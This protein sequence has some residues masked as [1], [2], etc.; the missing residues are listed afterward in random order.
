[1][2]VSDVELPEVLCATCGCLLPSQSRLAVVSTYEPSKPCLTVL[3]LNTAQV[4]T[5]LD[6]DVPA[7]LARY[8]PHASMICL[9]GG[10]GTVAVFDVRAGR[11]K[12]AGRCP[13]FP[14]K[15]QMVCSL[16]LAGNTICASALRSQLG[17]LGTQDLV[18][19]TSLRTL[20]IRSMR[21][22]GSGIYCAE[23]AASLRWFYGSAG[24]PQIL[25]GAPSGHLQLLDSSG[26]MGEPDETMLSLSQRGE[27]LLSLDVSATSQ[28][29]CAGGANGSL[30]IGALESIEVEQLQSNPYASQPELAEP[31]EVPYCPLDAPI[32]RMPLPPLQ[33]PEAG[34]T[35]ASAWP[36]QLMGK[37]G[38]RQ[39]DPETHLKASSLVP[40]SYMSLGSVSAAVY[41]NT[42]NRPPNMR[43]P[44]RERPR[45]AGYGAEGDYGL[46]EGEGEGERLVVPEAYAALKRVVVQ[47]GKF[48]L[49]EDFSFEAHNMSTALTTLDN[50]V[51]NC[52]CN[53]VL[54]IL[55]Q[56]PW[57]R[58]H[59]LSSLTRSQFVLSDELG[60]LFSMMDRSRGG[61]CQPR[62]F[63][64]ALHQSREATALK[65]VDAVDL[66]GNVKEGA[67]G[68]PAVI[69]KFTAFLLEHLNKEARE[70]ARQ[71]ARDAAA[72][73]EAA[74]LEAARK[75]GELLSGTVKP[76]GGAGEGGG[77][78][79]GK[80]EKLS[81]DAIVAKQYAER[82]AR[83]QQQQQ[84]KQEAS[85][86]TDG[87][88][89]AA[90]KDK[91]GGA[92][93]VFDELFGSVWQETFTF[94]GANAKDVVKESTSLVL[95]LTLP[96]DEPSQPAQQTPQAA[97]AAAGATTTQP[98]PPSAAAKA[99]TCSFE[100]ALAQCVCKESS[101]KT[102]CGELGK[103]RG[104][105]VTK[106]LRAAPPAMCLLTSQLGS[107]VMEEWEDAHGG[108]PWLPAAFR[109][110]LVDGEK[111]A[112]HAARAAGA[113]DAGAAE[114]AAAV[115][116]KGASASRCARSSASPQ[117]ARV[118]APAGSG[119]L[120]LYFRVPTARKARKAR[121]HAASAAAGALAAD[122]ADDEAAARAVVSA[123]VAA[124][125]AEVEAAAADAPDAEHEPCCEPSEMAGA[126]DGGAAQWY[127]WND[128][129][130]R[131]VGAEEV[132]TAHSDWKRPCIALYTVDGLAARLPPIP[133]AV[134]SPVATAASLS[135]NYSLSC[136]PPPT[137]EP[138]FTPLGPRELPPKRGMLVAIDAEFVA[139]TREVSRPGRHGKAVVV[140]PAR[141]ALARVSCVRGEG[142][143]AG[144]PFIDSYVQPAEPVVDYLT[145][146]SGLE[147]HDFM[148]G[149]GHHIETMKPVYLKL[150]QLIDAGVVFVG[151]G[152]KTDFE[153]INVVVPPSQ[154]V[155]TVNLFYLEGS[156]R[157]SLRF[158]AWHL[159]GEQMANRMQDKH[160]SIEDAR[161]A[162]QL[163]KLYVE[164]KKSGKVEETINR[165]YDVGR[166]TNWALPM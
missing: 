90:S 10:D 122:A 9:S 16:D 52:Y 120:I 136:P 110:S 78:K 112:V 24:P 88:G 129:A 5:K 125:I 53:V 133:T 22:S 32:G 121:S 128:F 57:L 83:Q 64:R 109:L 119:H 166:D 148:D 63:Q 84:V 70:G 97:A 158:L 65:L 71:A 73:L 94:P 147:A 91:E 85:A 138:T 96:S 66:H 68:L 145:R 30:T 7:T 106:Q 164:L 101:T 134:A 160:D 69:C 151:H 8:D 95:P 27:Q 150:R 92:R 124:S 38:A 54:L 13:L 146:F 162:L 26:T 29:I 86:A 161:V 118:A 113:D 152:L 72:K 114:A 153:M 42:S 103:Y 77:G 156:R 55:Y 61:A 165:L 14:S 157:I 18:F 111:P 81:L 79:T 46:E 141:L 140:K 75:E 127:A 135:V 34:A 44:L 33:E 37:R 142:P 1:M 41:R 163:Y 58:V 67:D 3:D 51:P 143:M 11:G 56:L 28:L 87:T 31:I 76:G 59:C 104:A 144:V 20:D 4:A 126:W 47:L 115:C 6:L 159:L 15:N 25:A 19:D 137:G 74:K 40:H 49:A 107:A 12:P 50:T 100:E 99:K 155:D 132:R 45:R 89:G 21:P 108:E 105:R 17:P 48:G 131:P 39:I 139:V 123:A 82:L 98:P 23:G 60:F 117:S 130:L 2:K 154:I 93:T 80:Q 116:A 62:N 36:A 43:L 102:W 149:I 35:P